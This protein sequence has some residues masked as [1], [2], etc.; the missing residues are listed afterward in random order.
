LQ[1]SDVSLLP[2]HDTHSKPKSVPFLS[3]LETRGSQ[4][5]ERTRKSY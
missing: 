5:T 3:G 1:G 4:K 2:L